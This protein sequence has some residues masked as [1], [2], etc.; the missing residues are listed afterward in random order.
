MFKSVS[1]KN[2]S[3]YSTLSILPVNCA[4]WEPAVVSTTPSVCLTAPPKYKKEPLGTPSNVP[5]N[6]P[7]PE[8]SY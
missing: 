4:V 6:A 8:S 2:L 3:K 5:L 7:D 1:S